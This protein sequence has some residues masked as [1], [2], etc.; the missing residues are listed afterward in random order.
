MVLHTDDEALEPFKV[1][2]VLRLK[3]IFN[4]KD[5]KLI[6]KKSVYV[7][8]RKPS[9]EELDNYSQLKKVGTALGIEFPKTK[10]KE[11]E[12]IEEL[13]QKVIEKVNNMEQHSWNDA[14]EYWKEISAKFPNVVY[15][16]AAQ[17]H[18]NEQK[19]TNDTSA[20]G[21]LFRV[22]IK[23]WIKLDEESNHAIEVL[24][25]KLEELNKEILSIVEKN[26]KQQ[27][28]LA[29]ELSQK[30]D[31]LDVSK[32]FSFTL[33]VKD[34]HGVQT[35]L[36]NRGS[37]LQ[38]AVLVA[39]IRSQA[40]VEQMIEKKRLNKETNNEEI[41]KSVIPST[42]YIFEEPEAFL[43]LGAQKELFYSL[44]DL[45]QKGNQVILTT[46][47]T[48]F[49][50]EADMR[51]IVLLK[52][53]KGQTYSLQHIPS[54]YIKDELGENIRISQLIT[55][56][57]CCIVEGLSD[58]FA[59]QSWM[60][61]LGYD[62]KRLGIHFISMDGCRNVDYFAN[63][64]ILNDFQVPFR[65]ILDNDR[66]GKS[67]NIGR[68]ESLERKFPKLKYGC[69]KLLNGELENYFPIEVVS[70]VLGIPMKYIDEEKYHF[71][72]KQELDDALQKA[73]RAGVVCARKYKEVDHAKSIAN[74]MAPEQIPDEII[75]IITELV[76]LATK[77]SVVE[78]EKQL[79]R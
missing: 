38:R 4:F 58:K 23:K 30:I 39:A 33:Y 55:G 8:N 18:E 15:I 43:H 51:D 59:F 48:L 67:D 65:I 72:P 28:V 34:S 25:D 24:T 31:P 6:I 70:E 47:S 60:N 41:Q 45:S 49:I 11:N 76:E 19:V 77:Q 13:K 52:R 12:K 20:F 36:Y 27:V 75:E 61:K 21:K 1:D 2:N 10:P 71:D 79:V 74:E 29:E 64:S 68:K 54:E 26:L 50:D 14:S 46:H 3:Q 69:I 5:G 44:K 78:M 32:G 17:D 7:E 56:K 57:V 22:G 73:Q 66:H 35:P 62:T 40:E 42:L 53:E 63:I 16:P 9:M 37:G